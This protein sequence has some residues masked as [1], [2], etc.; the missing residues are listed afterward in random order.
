M[1]LEALRS[2]EIPMVQQVGKIRL[3]ILR[4]LNFPRYCITGRLRT[5]L[6]RRQTHDPAVN[7]H[8]GPLKNKSNIFKYQ[9][10]HVNISNLTI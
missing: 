6:V 8:T 9:N 1:D 10:V 5:A 7:A 4:G 2:P 3:W